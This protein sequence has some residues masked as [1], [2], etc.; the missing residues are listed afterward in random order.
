MILQRRRAITF[1]SSGTQGDLAEG[2]GAGKKREGKDL[3][4]LFP[5]FPS[6]PSPVP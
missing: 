2:G 1:T 6:G 4:F 3:G 5:S